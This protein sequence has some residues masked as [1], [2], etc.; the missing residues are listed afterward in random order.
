MAR[1][2][3]PPSLRLKRI[4]PLEVPLMRS[5]NMVVVTALAVAIALALVG[6]VAYGVYT[7]FQDNQRKAAVRGGVVS[8]HAPG[9]PALEYGAL[10]SAAPATGA[11]T[12]GDLAIAQPAPGV[13]AP[14]GPPFGGAGG[15]AADG[16]SAW[17]VAYREVSDP[18]A[19]PDS[20]LVRAA[21]QDAE[22]KA[23]DLA[24][25]TGARLGKLLA[26]T[27]YS[28]NQPYYKPCVQNYL[29]PQGGPVP[30]GKPEA[31]GSGGAAPAPGSINGSTALTIAPM[32]PC[33]ANNNHYLVV[34]VYVRHAI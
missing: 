8:G 23:T 9:T 16:L 18:N 32:P 7:G 6:T 25:A 4:N 20:N 12:H 27:D 34:W 30:Q 11:A 21:F 19:Q 10:T 15:A 2:L 17:G 3:S 5:K 31:S 22:K 29:P 33:Q 1:E 14:G 28:N 26:L 24:T 13:F